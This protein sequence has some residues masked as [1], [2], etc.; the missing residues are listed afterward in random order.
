MGYSY[1]FNCRNCKHSQQLYEGWRFMD[2]DRTVE[3]ILN[4]SQI[5]LHY[6]TRQ[7]ITMLSK[8]HLQLQVKTEYKI[9]RCRCCLQLYDKLVVSV[10][11]GDQLLH[12]T[13]FKCASCGRHLKHTNIHRLK[14]AACPKCRS[15]QF[16]KSKALML[17][18]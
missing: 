11:S 14:F 9:Y 5:K 6:K 17:W 3:S 4:S 10:W 8:A 7:K 13:R 16:E 18:N 15:R 12:E 1:L 2:H